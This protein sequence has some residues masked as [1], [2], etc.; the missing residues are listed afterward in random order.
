MS[1][2]L[3]ETSPKKI[4]ILR[5]S[6]LGD[7]THVLPVVRAI[8]QQWPEAEIIW[9]CG[10]FEY[11]LLKTIKN[12]RFIPFNKKNGFK[13][14]VDLWKTLNNIKFDVLLH[15]QVAAR[16]NFASL[17][18]KADIKLGW[19]KSRS[20]DLHQFFINHSV[21]TVRQQH[22]VDGFLS[23]ARSLGVDV[24][25][26]AWKMPVTQGAQ[27]FAE[28]YIDK[29][30][31]VL[32]VSAC[33]SHHLR[34]WMSK[35]YA[36][37]ADY[38]VSKYDMQ[39]ILSGGPDDIEVDMANEIQ[40]YMKQTALNLVGRDTLEQ[41]VGL[42]SRATVVVSPDSG[43]AHL[44]NAV[45]VPVI[46]LYACTWSKRSG[47]YNS[48]HYCV[49]KFELAAKKY[50]HQSADALRWGSKIEEPGVMKLITADE[51]CQ[52]L[53]QV[54]ADKNPKDGSLSVNK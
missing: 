29:T 3:L 31:P 5:L 47:P 6:A 39:V 23:F 28:K 45:G 7:V 34:N 11:K 16:A 50:R 10:V 49:D 26:P 18:I 15:M 13:E 44:A 33:S 22:Q 2:T 54:M 19:D 12:I 51:V 30:K 46:G 25:K 20:R 52:R 14:Y 38:A 24:N 37:L 8:Q 43:P 32:I 48:L 36:M 27:A 53:D 21:A 40:G 4:C 42:L 9:I 41:L 17:G 35:R 1:A